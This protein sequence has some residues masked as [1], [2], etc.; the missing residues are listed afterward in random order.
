MI[1]LEVTR[2]ACQRVTPRYR[3]LGEIRLGRAPGNDVV[4]PDE[5]VSGEHARIVVVDATNANATNDANATNATSATSCAISARPTEPPCSGARSGSRSTR[6]TGARPLSK[7]ATSSSWGAATPSFMSRSRSATRRENCE[8][9]APTPTPSSAHVLATRKIDELGRVESTVERDDGRLRV[10]YEA[11]KRIGN[12]EDLKSVIVAICDGAFAL[13][14]GATHVTV[15]L[16]DDGDDDA[17][18]ATASYVPI[19]TRVR[20]QTGPAL[21][22]IPVTLQFGPGGARANRGH[23]GRRTR[24]S[25]PLGVAHGRADPERHRSAPLEGR[26]QGRRDPR[27]PADGQSR[28]HRRLHQRR[29]RRQR[30]ASTPRVAG[31]RQRAP[32]ASAA[33]GGGA[34]Q[35]GE[36]IPQDARRAAAG[37][38]SRPST[39]SSVRARRCARSSPTSSRRWSTRA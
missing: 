35:E 11:Q 26:R 3:P 17:P 38:L 8:P 21:A 9:R 31:R 2:R 36:R 13:V 16:R 10:L 4:L 14:P 24:R 30:G 34:P 7:R 33:C 12:A 15:V 18:G 22:P 1:L 5:H 20:G 25:G 29:P 37:R 39:R 28:E 6:A 27:R 32:G 23:R 19:A